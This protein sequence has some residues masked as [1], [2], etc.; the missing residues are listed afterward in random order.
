M[1]FT[2]AIHSFVIFIYGDMNW[3]P[4]LLGNPYIISGFTCDGSDAQSTYLSIPVSQR[5]KP[6]QVMGNTG[7]KGC[8]IY[9]LDNNLPDFINPF[10][11]CFEWHDGQQDT[12]FNSRPL[13]PCS[14]FI[15]RRDFRFAYVGYELVLSST[16]FGK[17]F[18]NKDTSSYDL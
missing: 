17:L 1:L 12:L 11:F 7:Q 8:W 4:D 18:I 15:A 13:C 14:R 10:K 6:D 2:D 9:Q 3:N 5:Y 16:Y